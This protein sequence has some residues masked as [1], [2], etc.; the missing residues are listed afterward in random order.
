[1]TMITNSSSVPLPQEHFHQLR[2]ELSQIRMQTV[3]M[4]GAEMLRQVTFPP[5]Q[6]ECFQRGFWRY[7]L[8]ASW[9][10]IHLVNHAIVSPRW[11][12]LLLPLIL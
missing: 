12:K 7:R 6:V 10:R 2:D 1:M 8:R 5:V 11:Q 3:D 9:L 4:L